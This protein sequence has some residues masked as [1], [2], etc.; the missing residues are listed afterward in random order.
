MIPDR[1][2]SVLLPILFVWPTIHAG[3]PDEFVH[4]VLETIEAQVEKAKK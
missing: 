3:H 4:K 1:V 2:A